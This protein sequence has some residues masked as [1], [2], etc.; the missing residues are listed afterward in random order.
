M[1]CINIGQ[2]RISVI[3]KNSFAECDEDIKE[4]L[5]TRSLK[6]ENKKLME[7]CLA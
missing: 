4:E 1:K 2:I 3:E 6:P 7:K 5:E